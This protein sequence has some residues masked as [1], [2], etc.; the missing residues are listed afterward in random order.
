MLIE[1]YEIQVTSPPCEPGSERWSAFVTFDTDISDMLPYLNAVWADAVYDHAARVLT[2]H[3]QGRAIAVRPQQL[4]VSNLLDRSEAV[5]LV[6]QIIREINEIWARRQE[7]TPCLEKKKRPGVM[8]IYKL[9]P[10][11]N[12]GVCGQ[13]SCF[14]F[15]LQLVAGGADITA[16]APLDM[17]EYITQRQSLQRLLGLD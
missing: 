11:T 12:C 13:S 15:A 14:T 10:R 17:P 5:A 8:D 9:L 4:A 3:S 1:A 16:C 6:E 2:R 7:I